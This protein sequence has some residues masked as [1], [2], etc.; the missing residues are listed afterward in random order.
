MTCRPIINNAKVGNEL[1]SPSG[2]CVVSNYTKNIVPSSLCVKFQLAYAVVSMVHFTNSFPTKRIQLQL[3]D[4]L[5]NLGTIDKTLGNI[6]MKLGT[7]KDGQIPPTSIM[8]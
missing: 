7:E 2:C 1:H 4:I 3:G 8:L 5:T 6:M